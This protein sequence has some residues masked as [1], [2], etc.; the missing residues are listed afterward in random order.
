MHSFGPSATAH[1]NSLWYKHATTPVGG[2]SRSQGVSCTCATAAVSCVDASCAEHAAQHIMACGRVL[3]SCR[4]V[5][6]LSRPATGLLWLLHC[7]TGQMGFS[8][9]RVCSDCGCCCNPHHRLPEPYALKPSTRHM[10]WH[11]Q[12]SLTSLVTE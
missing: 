6:S 12:H 9:W 3:M 10:I 11:G 1:I 4:R 8:S 7:F 2:T 5:S